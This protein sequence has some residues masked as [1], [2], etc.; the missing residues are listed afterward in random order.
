MCCAKSLNVFP[1]NEGGVI[2]WFNRGNS[3]I[4]SGLWTVH[5]G[6]HME[7][8]IS[9]VGAVGETRAAREAV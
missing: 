9:G 3:V 5:P 7:L 2:E 6:A 8:E 4:P 1:V